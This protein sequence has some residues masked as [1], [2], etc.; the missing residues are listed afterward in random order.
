M[1]R[2]LRRTLLLWLL[3][4][5]VAIVPAA[6]ALQYALV[7]RPTQEAFDKALGDATLAVAAFVRA[8]AQGPE[9]DMDPQA[10][11]ALRTDQ[12]D[13]VYYAVLA[14]DGRR[15]AGDPELE[16]PR[17][18]LAADTWRF[19]DVQLDGAA[20][21]MA[22]RGVGCGTAV[23]QVRV[24]ETLARRHEVLREALIG[25]AAGVLAFALA[26]VVTVLLATRQALLPL[27]RLGAQVG[28]RS[29]DDLREVDAFEAPAE[30]HPLVDAVNRLFGRVREGSRAQQAFLADAAHQLRTP[31]A[32]LKNETELAL[33]EPHPA[34]MHAT[35]TRLAAGASRAARLA[36]Q[37]LALARSDSASL[38][39]VPAE[40]V[41]LRA[42]AADA[43]DEWVPRALA[44]GVDLGF[45]LDPARLRGRPFLLRE[46]LANLIHNALLHG[47]RGCQVTVR[48][49]QQGERCLLEVEDDGPGIPAEERLRIFERFQRG[50]GA[51]LTGTGLGL[52]IVR[53]IARGHGGS[54]EV[55]D[56]PGGRGVVLRVCLPVAGVL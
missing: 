51:P 43:A 46:L 47:G 23:C 9:F 54:V 6:A 8:G 34:D 2:S 25:T 15:I 20:V 31:L 33:A 12:F 17:F 55:A 26:T 16:A 11:R 5:L 40:A 42:L 52:A 41:D 18:R 21:R 35:L 45:D 49:R 10:E 48:T 27:G 50:A 30:V 28:T 1:A 14:P 19:D 37:L 3:V 56:P 32:A 38:H 22:A 24:A 53:D 4:P 39:A 13:T 44:A 7:L 36:S 29:L